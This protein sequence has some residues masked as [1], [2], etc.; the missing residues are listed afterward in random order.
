[1]RISSYTLCQNMTSNDTDDVIGRRVDDLTRNTKKAVII[2]R[3]SQKILKTCVLVHLVAVSVFGENWLY[4]N[5]QIGGPN[6][7]K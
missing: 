4:L 2:Y 6:F 1:M 3:F 7:A 5:F